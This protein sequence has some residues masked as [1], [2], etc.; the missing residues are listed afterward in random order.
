MNA[1]KIKKLREKKNLT[2]D[3]LARLC[4]VS[5]PAVSMWEADK[6]KP[7]KSSI[8]L[9]ELVQDGVIK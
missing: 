9:L 4:G 8:L 5:A 6:K 7:C 1:I 3:Q 2:Q